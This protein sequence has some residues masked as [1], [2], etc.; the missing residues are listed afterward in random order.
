MSNKEKIIGIF[1][2]FILITVILVSFFTRLKFGI[3]EIIS[4]FLGSVF[5]FLGI[6]IL[7]WAYIYIGKGIWGSY[8]PRIDRLVK[9]G[10]YRFVRHPVYLSTILII[11][12]LTIFNRSIVSLLIFVFIYLPLLSYRIRLEEKALYKTFKQEWEEWRKETD[13]IFPF[14]IF[15]IRFLK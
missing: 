1:Y 4:K 11:L 2:V 12:G 9:K 6:L 14:K 3:N 13:L 5:L 8:T 7:I 15:K 10:P